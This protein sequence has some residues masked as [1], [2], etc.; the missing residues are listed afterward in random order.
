[1][2]AGA[3]RIVQEVGSGMNGRRKKL[4]E[5]LRGDEDILVEHRDRLARFGFEYIE[6]S[7]APRKIVVLEQKEVED[8]LIRDM[9]E[10]L[11]SF[12][13]RLYGRRSAASRA[14]R[15]VECARME[16]SAN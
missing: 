2:A 11:T 8:D 16:S 7:I 14:R 5:L 4:L 12:C 10:V 3:A 1:M 15:A 13:A 9:T 6:A